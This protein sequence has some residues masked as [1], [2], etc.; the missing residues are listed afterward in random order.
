[1]IKESAGVTECRDRLDGGRREFRK[2]NEVLKGSRR[3]VK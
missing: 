3:K 1:M 2:V